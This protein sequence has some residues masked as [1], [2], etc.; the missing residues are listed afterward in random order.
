[1]L[2]QSQTAPDDVERILELGRSFEKLKGL[3]SMIALLAAS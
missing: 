3:E 1:L 2:P